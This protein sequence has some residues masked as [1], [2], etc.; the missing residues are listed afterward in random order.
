MNVDELR[1]RFSDEQACRQFLESVIWPNGRVCPHC[2][3]RKSY[4]IRGE[5]SRPGLYECGRCKHQFTV[6]TR[7]PLH[8]TKLSLWKW[9]QAMYYMV[10]SSKGISSG[11]LAKWIGISQKSAWKMGHA[12]RQMMAPG[13]ES[14]PVLNGIVE[15]D[16]KYFGGKPRY[17]KGVQHKR[18][19]GTAKQCVFVAVQRNGPVRTSPVNSDRVCELAPL[20]Q[21]FVHQDS[22]LMTDENHVYISIGSQ[23]AAHSSVNHGE[24]EY[25][26]GDVHNNTAESFN[27]LLE[28]AKFG[29]FHYMSKKHLFRYLDEIG[30]RWDHRIPERKKTKKGKLKT[31]MNP[32]P[33]LMMLSSVL[34]RA[35]GRQL[36]RSRNGGILC[37]MSSS[38][39]T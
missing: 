9:I 7:T 26:R 37:P 31:I 11:F 16:E 23:Y 5:S 24:K 39:I 3:F 36:R 4:P 21:G 22:R 25:A 38:P 33:L 29:V 34:S 27:S 14:Q 12:I 32:M 6:T 15:L 19:K 18:G 17:E 30:F 13:D 35:L 28:R 1:A 20:V 10:N 8:S 2:S